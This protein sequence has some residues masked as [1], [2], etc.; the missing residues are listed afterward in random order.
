MREGVH[1]AALADSVCY[2]ILCGVSADVCFFSVLLLQVLT[3]LATVILLCEFL[4][5]TCLVL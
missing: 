3:G 2:R 1:I 5:K 4:F